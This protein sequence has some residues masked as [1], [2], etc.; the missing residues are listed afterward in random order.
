MAGVSVETSDIVLKEMMTKGTLVL[1]ESMYVL[2][3][4][5]ISK[6]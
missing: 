5:S 6:R 4:A 3:L 2:D 1:E